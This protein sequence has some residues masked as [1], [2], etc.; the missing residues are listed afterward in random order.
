M[1]EEGVDVVISNATPLQKLGADRA[2]EG[3]GFATNLGTVREQYHP[4]HKIS[5]E[6]R[7]GAWAFAKL[8][9]TTI[10]RLDRLQA[11][12]EKR[13]AEEGAIQSATTIQVYH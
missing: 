12:L 5:Q 10:G 6:Q 1:E 8:P 4:V 3:F 2:D 7:G 9:R 11:T 13:Q